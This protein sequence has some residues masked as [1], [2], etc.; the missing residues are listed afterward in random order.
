M[1]QTAECVVGAFEELTTSLWKCEVCESFVSIHSPQ[2]VMH[3]SCPACD[4]GI[5]SYCGNFDLILG[6]RPG[7]A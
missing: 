7:D 4:Q 5:L 1:T 6:N 3:A 2:L